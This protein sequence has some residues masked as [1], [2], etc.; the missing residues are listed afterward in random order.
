MPLAQAARQLLLLDI[1]DLYDIGQRLF[2]V[3]IRASVLIEKI[4]CRPLLYS[5]LRK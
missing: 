3:V 1:H 4:A 2:S 5:Y